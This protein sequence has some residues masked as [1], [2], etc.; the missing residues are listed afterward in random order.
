MKALFSGTAVTIWLVRAAWLTMP[1]VLGSALTDAVADR[2]TVMRIVVGSAA[3]LIWAAVLGASLILRP[4]TL[5]VLRTLVPISVPAAIWASAVIG[6]TPISVLGIVFAFVCTFTA[7]AAATGDAFVDGASYGDE[8]RMPL[9]VPGPLTPIV[10]LVWALMVGLVAAGMILLAAQAWLLGAVAALLA[11]PAVAIGGR[12]LHSLARRWIVFVPAGIVLHDHLSLQAPVLF[13]RTVIG[14]MRPVDD[15][16]KAVD[17]TQSAFG[18]AIGVE[19]AEPV[20]ATVI[21]KPDGT[22]DV[23]LRAFVF[24]PSRPGAVLDHAVRRNL[25]RR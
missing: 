8:R 22:R 2:S 13:S 3:W 21:E 16:G 25:I 11:L 9:R 24:S 14:D 18:L 17:F 10:A 7:L 12:A 19:L 5:T 6:L 23:A 1:F 20:P 4:I 15:P